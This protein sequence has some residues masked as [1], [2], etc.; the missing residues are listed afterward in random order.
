MLKW[1]SKSQLLLHAA[2]NPS[3]FN[4]T[5]ATLQHETQPD[6]FN[7]DCNKTRHDV[8]VNQMGST[9]TATRQGLTSTLTASRQQAI[10]HMRSAKR[11]ERYT[12]TQAAG[13]DVNCNKAQLA[14]LNVDYNEAQR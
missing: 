12:A 6:G 10:K 14:E 9:S 11:V 1:D 5:T 8:N 2:P 7:V 13:V 4:A 3:L